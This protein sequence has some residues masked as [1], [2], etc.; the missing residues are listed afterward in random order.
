M[1]LHHPTYHI[2][3]D[4]GKP[5]FMINGIIDNEFILKFYKDD[6]KNQ[7][8][9]SLRNVSISLYVKIGYYKIILF[10]TLLPNFYV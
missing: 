7:E 4:P 3:S 9:E 2:G 5:N 8:L 1:L 6:K 10:L